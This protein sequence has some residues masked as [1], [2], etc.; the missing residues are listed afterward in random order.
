MK[1]RIAIIGA[2]LSGLTLA[3]RLSAAAEVVVFEKARGVG[4][5]MATRRFEPY[6]FDHGAPYFTARSAEFKKFL[7]P[8][9]ASGLVQEWKGKVITLA[10]GKKPGKRIWYEPHYVCCPAMNYLCKNLSEG[11]DVRTQC[12]VAPLL[13]RQ[14]NEWPIADTQGNQLGNY[15]LVI[16]TAPPAQTLRLLGPHLPAR[17]G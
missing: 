6:S 9:L 16:S 15:D 1:Q 3:S 11:I 5:R 2:G 17:A 4:G 7:A 13:A 8:R 12:E 10:K 14:G